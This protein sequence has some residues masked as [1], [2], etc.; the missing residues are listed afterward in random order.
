MTTTKTVCGTTHLVP[1]DR[2][3]DWGEDVT[4]L[5]EDLCDLANG[6]PQA[7]TA[8]GAATTINFSL[9]KNVRLTLNA[10]T[11]LTLTNPRNGRPGVII[12]IYGGAYT[13]TFP[14]T[15]KWPRG[16]TAPTWTSVAG[17]VDMVG[18]FWDSTSG[19]Y[20]AEVSTGYT[21]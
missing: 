10:N 1:E 17:Q 5:L 19:V 2:E 3:R 9:G 6:A 7:V 11:T 13:P 15:V 20:R 21:A 18:L 16:G 12:I 14:S 8:S 4:D